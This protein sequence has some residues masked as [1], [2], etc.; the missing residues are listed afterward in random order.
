MATPH[1]YRYV[2]PNTS[3]T[4]DNDLVPAD[5]VVPRPSLIRI[6]IAVDA[7]RILYLRVKDSVPAV[8]DIPM[9]KGVAIAAAEGVHE[10]FIDAVPEVPI[11]F[12]LSGN[13]NILY[14]VVNG[15][16]A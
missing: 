4:F 13:C 8:Y 6:A 7:D 2:T 16:G 9:N 15:V 12:S 3:Y 1:N 5:I 10:F 14:L 11:N